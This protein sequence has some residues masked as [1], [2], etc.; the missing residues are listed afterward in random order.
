M[1]SPPPRSPERGEKSQQYASTK[2]YPAR[3]GQDWTPIPGASDDGSG[4][5]NRIMLMHYGDGRVLA[6]ILMSLKGNQ[7]RVAVKDADDVVELQLVNGVW[8]SECCEPVTFEFPTA[9]FHAVGIV[10]EAH[11]L[12]PQ[13]EFFWHQE[14]K[15][16]IKNDRTN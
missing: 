10:P 3:Y 11:S 7:M 16:S 5:G 4:T 2:L 8:I 14:T 9:V 15:A 12:N 1:K 6:G 13:A